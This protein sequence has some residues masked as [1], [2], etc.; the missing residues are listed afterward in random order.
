MLSNFSNIEVPHHIHMSLPFSPQILVLCNSD[1]LK[2]LSPEHSPSKP[3]LLPKIDYV[4]IAYL[5]PNAFLKFI[6]IHAYFFPH[7]FPCDLDNSLKYHPLSTIPIFV[8]ITLHHRL[9]FSFMN[10]QNHL[11]YKVK[12]ISTSDLNFKQL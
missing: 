7:L 4:P 1:N 5:K 11:P 9:P 2:K 8:F 3:K 10:L 6:F 12:F